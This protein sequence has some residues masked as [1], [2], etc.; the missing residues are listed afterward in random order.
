VFLYDAVG[1]KLKKTVTD[2]TGSTAK[3]TTTDYI[4]GL[5]YQNDTLQFVSHEEG[6]IRPLFK[7][8]QPLSYAYD[9]FIKDHLGNI[10]MLL[11]EQTGQSLYAAT[12]ETENA[13]KENALFSN[14][15]NTRTA[16]PPGY[17]ADATTNPNNYVAKLNAVNGQK[18]GPSLVLRVMAGDTIQLGVKAFYKS[19][20]ANTSGTT[21]SSMLAAL[22]Q[23]FSGSSLSDGSH[24]G[25]GSSSA[26]ATSF[27]SSDYDELIEKDPAQ[28]LSD[29][30][31]AYMNYA[32]FDDQFN[33][34]NENSGVKQVQG[35]P[36]ELQTLGTDRMVIKETGFMYIYTSNE[37][38]ED[39]FFD[40]LVVAHNSGP[41]LEETHYYPFGL[42]MAG[43]SSKA[44]KGAGYPENRLKYNGKEL[45]N[46]EFKDGSG[47][48]LYSYGAR[49][50]DSQIGRW[51]CIDPH[52]DRY[53]ALSP[54]N[55]VNNNPI[56]FIDP[57]GMD[58][59]K[60]RVPDGN[61]GVKFATVD[62]KIANLA[63][64]F[65]W[66]MYEKYGAVVTESYRTDLQQKNVSGSGGLKA[67]VGKSRHQQ[68]FA[69]DIGVNSAFS[70]KYGHTATKSE[71]T[72]VGEYGEGLGLGW[73]WR[74][75]LRDYP[76]FEKTATDYGYKSLQEAYI[77]NKADYEKA[78]GKDGL[79]TA[80]F[81]EEIK[82]VTIGGKE[83]E[84]I[85]LTK[86]EVKAVVD[87][88]KELQ[89][90]NKKK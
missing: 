26:I 4:F 68:G 50:F 87:Y 31:R 64:N 53:V 70:K 18:I 39:V 71:K 78:G 57:N 82:K 88:I 34:V 79:P 85:Q 11:T 69:L 10:R 43:I 35:S 9:Y 51:G 21:S 40:N 65:A 20:A 59:I 47:L 8:G 19:T 13:E 67:K 42:S 29:K 38:G 62:S 63:Y 33:M 80:T 16:L 32:L 41:L 84:G 74:Y 73:D 14:I 83:Y 72:E 30:P 75:K 55:Y 36:D 81:N 45:Q 48:E 7:T 12:M 49:M 89:E 37:S 28:N 60:I 15:D 6:R 25:T 17:P 76:H 90:Q 54:Y 1:N 22:V 27:N 58:L 46:E 2:N 86:E 61:G 5:V 66:A 52:S 3:I 77:V 44:L 24:T 23:A 56:I